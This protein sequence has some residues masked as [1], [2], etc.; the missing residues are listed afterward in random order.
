MPLCFLF[1][2]GTLYINDFM[3][4][5]TMM[6]MEM[7]LYQNGR[8]REEQLQTRAEDCPDIGQPVLKA[9]GKISKISKR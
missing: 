8:C 6:I 5:M 4:M 9:A 3:M 1:V 2:A 7:L